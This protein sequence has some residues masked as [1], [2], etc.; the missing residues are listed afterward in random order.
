MT[1]DMVALCGLLEKRSE[2]A[3]LREVIGFTARRLMEPE[4]QGL[5]A[6]ERRRAIKFTDFERRRMK[7][8]GAESD[9]R[10]QAQTGLAKQPPKDNAANDF[11]STSRT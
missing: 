10:Y 9:R 5:T 11:S 7:A 8:I 3:L 2:A 6:A 1:D 4:V